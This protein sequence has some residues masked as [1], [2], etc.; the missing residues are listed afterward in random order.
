MAKKMI[1]FTQPLHV[2]TT[3]IISHPHFVPF[4]STPITLR[5]HVSLNFANQW[6]RVAA[7]QQRPKGVPQQKQSSMSKPSIMERDNIETNQRQQRF[8]ET[9]ITQTDIITMLADDDGN[10]NLGTGGALHPARR[11]WR[12]QGALSVIG[13]QK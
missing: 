4:H 13:R 9:N 1:P 6:K 3:P 5:S 12:Q 10:S 8:T 11:R 7:V 2:N